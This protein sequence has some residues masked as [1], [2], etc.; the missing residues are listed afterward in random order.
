MFG[1]SALSLIAASSTGSAG[2]SRP[3]V[4]ASVASQ[5][6]SFIVRQSKSPGHPDLLRGPAPCPLERHERIPRCRVLGWSEFDEILDLEPG[7]AQ[8][9]DPVAVIEVELHALL[10]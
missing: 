6:S 9:A 10:V 4:Y 8:E 7:G 2:W 5:R 1:S 3:V